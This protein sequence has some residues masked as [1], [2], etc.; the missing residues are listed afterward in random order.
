MVTEANASILRFPAQERKPKVDSLFDG[1]A[2][3]VE[4]GFHA[5]PHLEEIFFR[6]VVDG[7]RVVA[8]LIG[9]CLECRMPS[10]AACV[11]A[12]LRVIDFVLV[13]QLE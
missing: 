6:E 9:V 2:Q 8:A 10:Y 5:R 12:D 11:D 4:R 1:F 7:V 3:F 13:E